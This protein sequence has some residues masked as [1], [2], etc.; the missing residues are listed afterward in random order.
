MPKLK[1]DSTAM[2]MNSKERDR[3]Y[4]KLDA[5]QRSYYESIVTKSVVCVDAPAGTGKTSVAVLAG[6]T[7]LAQGSIARLV[8]LRFPDDR[9]LR[10]GYLPGELDDKQMYYMY[11]FME[12]CVDLGLQRETVDDLVSQGLIEL[13]TDIGMRGR[14]LRNSMVILDE[15]QNAK[16]GDLKLVLTRL[17]DDS[18]C[19]IIGHQG[20][21]DNRSND[22]AFTRYIDHLTKKDWAVS[23][24]L[25]RNYRGRISRWADELL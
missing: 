24:V 2:L 11:P 13:C 12:A 10:L 4:G 17:T 21:Q 6:L 18:K 3:F 23:C 14:T 5:D 20:Q 25:P 15:T 9:S 7:L 19:V 16:F 22:H 1:L 8:Y